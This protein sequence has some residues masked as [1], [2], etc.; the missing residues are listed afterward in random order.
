MVLLAC[1]ACG[2]KG[3]PLPPLVRIP[4][5]PADITAERR[6]DLVEIRFLVPAGN[7]DGTRPANIQRVE[8]F[9]ISA[10]QEVSDEHIVRD[11]TRIASVEVVWR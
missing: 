4:A 7:V 10:A 1:T 9:A 5:A 8:V 3:P 6:G 2:R 11:G